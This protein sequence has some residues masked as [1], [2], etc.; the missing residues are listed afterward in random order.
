[1][2]DVILVPVGGTV[3]SVVGVCQNHVGVLLGNL[4][5]QGSA[6]PTLAATINDWWCQYDSK[7]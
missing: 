5:Y 1:M 6:G 7:N 2:G 4:T 3:Q